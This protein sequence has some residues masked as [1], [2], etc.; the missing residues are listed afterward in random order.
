MSKTKQIRA[1]TEFKNMLNRIRND[2]RI[3]GLDERDL[4]DRRLTLAISRVPDLEEFV[5]KSKI[6]Q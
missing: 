6:T 1:D 2:R 5:K 4:S 3:K